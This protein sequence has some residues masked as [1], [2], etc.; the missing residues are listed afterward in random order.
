MT[1]EPEEKNFG[2][3]LA[4]FR[5][6]TKDKSGKALSQENFALAMY[7]IDNT[8]LFTGDQIYKWEKGKSTFRPS[9]RL[10]LL[11]ILQV[12][13]KYKGIKTISEASMLVHF[14]GLK[15]LEEQE[16]ANLHLV[17][18]ITD[19]FS[20]EK[21]ANL[22]EPHQNYTYGGGSRKLDPMNFSGVDVF[23]NRPLQ[24]M[25]GLDL[26]STSRLTNSAREEK[27][28][29]S[30]TSPH[31]FGLAP[32]LPSIFIGR[33]KAMQELR[34]RLCRQNPA[35]DQNV[36]VLTAIRGW[37]GVGK[38]STASVLAHDPEVMA[39]FPDG[40]LWTSLR[41]NPNILPALLSWG[42]AM[43]L[44]IINKAKNVSEASAFLAAYLRN[45]QMLL[46]IDDVWKSS[47]A[48]PFMIGGQNCA[49]LLTTRLPIIASRL[50]AS[51]DQIYPLNVLEEEDSFTLM[52]LIAPQV[53]ESYPEETY[54]LIRKL[55]G[56]PLALQVAG[57][58]LQAEFST[59][60]SVNDLI[61]EISST[62]RILNE[63]APADQENL[64][65][66]TTPTIAALLYRSLEHLDEATRNK[67][68]LLGAIAPSPAKFDQNI[69]ASIWQTHNPRP[70]IKTLVDRG[71]LEYLPKSQLFQMHS[72][73]VML[74]QSLWIDNVKPGTDEQA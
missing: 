25:E 59:G 53:V 12:L 41:V 4:Y 43:G 7:E 65:N 9:D 50:V 46:I 14:S 74:A 16:I 19:Y 28:R 62:S 34:Q 17:N 32:A 42:T 26:S 37:P 8:V 36:Q 54:S 66:A 47:D 35:E 57:R 58:L 30:D 5:H 73:L 3:Y 15:A 68:A 22:S 6:Q 63:Q 49:T 18:P 38:T 27:F 1:L 55:E 21:P 61:K 29:Y 10:K 45:K 70:M 13:V 40:V 56:L 52:Q 11:T 23:C 44:D 67:Y 48:L 24:P 31:Y 51:P 69:I 60:Y 33:E 71:L 20:Q 2:S 64:S 72:L 39:H